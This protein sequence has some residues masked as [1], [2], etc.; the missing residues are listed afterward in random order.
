MAVWM[1]GVTLVGVIGVAIGLAPPLLHRAL[2]HHGSARA[3]GAHRRI[4]LTYDDGPGPPLTPRRHA[5]LRAHAA[6]APIVILGSRAQTDPDTVR[7]VRDAG[8]E[9]G[10]HSFAHLR[11]W[12]AL[13]WRSV[14]D[15]AADG[16]A[17][18]ILGAIPRLVRPPYGKM[19]LATWLACLLRGRRIAWWTIDSGDT[20]PTLPDP[21]AMAK[22]VID[23]GGGVVLLHDFDREGHADQGARQQYVLDVT[24]EIL[25]AG[26]R[27]GFTF[28]RYSDLCAPTVREEA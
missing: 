2:Q 25:A 28:C 17:E 10:T 6:A 26:S 27:A 15:L 1:A 14:R 5:R 24:R 12:K 8:H 20:W 16:W 19:T 23:A 13:P 9:I 11:A 7:A 3:A 18:P 21:A 22:S 4:A